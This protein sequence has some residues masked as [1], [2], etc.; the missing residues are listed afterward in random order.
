MRTDSEFEELPFRGEI[1]RP[2]LKERKYKII[3][4]IDY[5]EDQEAEERAKAKFK[6]LVKEF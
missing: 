4:E 5:D 3:P 6:K 2:I 1:D